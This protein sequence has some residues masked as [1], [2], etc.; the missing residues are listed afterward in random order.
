MSECPYEHLPLT[1]HVAAWGGATLA[2]FLVARWVAGTARGLRNTWR[3]KRESR[4]GED[5]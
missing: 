5:R 1:V 3:F 2:G 4:R